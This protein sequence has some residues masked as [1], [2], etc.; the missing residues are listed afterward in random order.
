MGSYVLKRILYMIPTLLVISVITFIIIQLPPGDYLTSYIATL[1]Q[2]GAMVSEAEIASLRRQYGL[3][4]PMVVQYLQWMWK[5][6]HG[7]FGMS[8]QWNRPVRT[9]IGERLGLT[10]VISTATLVFTWVVAIPIGIYSAMRQYSLGDYVATVIGMLGVAVPNFLLAL[11]IMYFAYTRFGLNITGLF[12]REMA[13]APGSV[14]KF[15]DM[16]KHIWAPVIVVGMAGTAQL[17]RIMRAGLLDE[18]GKPYVEAARAKGIP[19]RRLIFKY[20]VRLAI[21]PLVSTI[22]WS[23][24]GIISGETIVSVVLSLETTGPLLLRALLSQDMYLAGSFILMLSLLTV[25][26]T[27]ISDILLALLDPRIRYE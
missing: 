20:P 8:F 10:M 22:G 18:L 6:L 27:L 21:N 23:L 3:D 2:S 12:S 13:A 11:V 14:A 9:L 15:V 16:L 19:E 1:E 7:D 24:P 17:I 4:Q 26:G 5:L 25:I